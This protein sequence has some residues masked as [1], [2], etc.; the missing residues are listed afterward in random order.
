MTVTETDFYAN[1]H[2]SERQFGGIECGF[3]LNNQS[4]HFVQNV[5]L[6]G[7][8]RS[9]PVFVSFANGGEYTLEIT[10]ANNLPFGSCLFIEDV[11]TG[12]TISVLKGEKLSVRID[13]PISANY[14]LVHTS[15][16]AIVNVTNETCYTSNNGAIQLEIATGDWNLVLEGEQGIVMSGKNYFNFRNLSAGEYSLYATSENPQCQSDVVTFTITQPEREVYELL[17]SE[18]DECNVSGHGSIEFSFTGAPFFEYEISSSDETIVASAIATEPIVIVNNL[19]GDEYT[20]HVNSN[21]SFKNYTVDINDPNAISASIVEDEITVS[22]LAG[23]SKTIAIEQNSTNAETFNWSLDNGFQSSEETF[24]YQFNQP[25]DH[26]LMLIASNEYCSS[27]DFIQI[28][29]AKS[30]RITNMETAP[31]V[32][33]MQKED[34]VNFVFNQ[35]SGVTAKTYLLDMTGKQ[36]WS[37]GGQASSGSTISADISSLPAGAYTA[38]VLVNDLPLLSRKMI[39]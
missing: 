36:V 19:Q 12:A 23:E 26:T 39:R 32:S 22:L 6:S 7:E 16:A 35:V 33:F 11:I 38:L 18:V 37:G 1:D 3:M 4:L 27:A 30:A 28:N 24:I 5:P 10:T 34:E 14:F 17:R 2:L 13:Q 31:Y 21:C 8:K 29:V 9:I 15:P 25:G 20:I